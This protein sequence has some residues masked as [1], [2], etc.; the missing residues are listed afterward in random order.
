MI[1]QKIASKKKI[2][3]DPKIIKICQNRLKEKKFLNSLNNVKT[4]KFFEINNFEDLKKNFKLINNNGILK[5]SEF[6]Y[7]GKGQYKIFN[8]QIKTQII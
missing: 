1:L 7:D 2:F 5:T 8:G 4:A 3:P 6:G